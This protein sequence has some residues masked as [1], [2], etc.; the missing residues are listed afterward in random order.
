MKV[1]IPVSLASGHEPLWYFLSESYCF[2]LKDVHCKP[3]NNLSLNVPGTVLWLL[4]RHY[5]FLTKRYKTFTQWS[6]IRN[7]FYMGWTISC[8]QNWT[9][10]PLGYLPNARSKSIIF[11][12]VNIRNC[13]ILLWLSGYLKLSFFS[14]MI[15]YLNF[16]QRY[17][18]IYFM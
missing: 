6:D 12:C 8:V 11:I 1:P 5:F 18:W 7:D 10:R 16:L 3:K 15:F 2:R 17:T 9:E 13:H 4:F 14:I